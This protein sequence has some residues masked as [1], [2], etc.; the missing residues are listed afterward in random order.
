MSDYI[1][2][3]KQW[4]NEQSVE[5]TETEG[6]D[7]KDNPKLEDEQAEENQKKTNTC[8]R[9]GK[10]FPCECQ[11]KDSMDTNTAG[12]FTGKKKIKEK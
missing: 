8:P 11:E 1:K 2:S 12:R 3:F 7:M 9:C 10:N 6:F 5:D 4:L